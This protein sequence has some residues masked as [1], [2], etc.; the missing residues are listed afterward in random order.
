L[1][2]ELRTGHA[3]HAQ[4]LIVHLDIAS[5]GFFGTE[6]RRLRAFAEHSHRRRALVLSLVEEAASSEP[7]VADRNVRRCY[8]IYRRHISLRLRQHF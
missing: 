8:A 6:E 2:A 5:D 1:H 4:P 7:Q 3:D